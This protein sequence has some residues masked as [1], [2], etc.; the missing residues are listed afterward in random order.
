MQWPGVGTATGVLSC[1]CAYFTVETIEKI[2]APQELQDQVDLVTG[3]ESYKIHTHK[4]KWQV[5]DIII[6]RDTERTK[7]SHKVGWNRPLLDNHK[8]DRHQKNYALIHEFV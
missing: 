2:T 1:S 6:G 5:M 4:S 8:T 3:L 7:S